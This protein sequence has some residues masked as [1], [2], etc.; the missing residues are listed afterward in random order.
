MVG[1]SSIGI[2][3][4]RSRLDRALIGKAWGRKQPPGEKAVA[5]F[6]EDALTMAVAAALRCIG[7]GDAA[8]IDGLF[9]ASTS[10]PYRE[11]QVASYVATAC[12][13]LEP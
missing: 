6:D 4:P 12:D 8:S 2:Y 13:L 10:S 1:I 5:H 3:V 7:D 9:F 11:K